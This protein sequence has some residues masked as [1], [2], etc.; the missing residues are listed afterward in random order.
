VAG[1]MIVYSMRKGGDVRS[2]SEPNWKIAA[3]FKNKI[4]RSKSFIAA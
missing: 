1:W 2:Q 4:S 3:T